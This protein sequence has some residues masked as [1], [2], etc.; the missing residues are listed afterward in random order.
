VSLKGNL[1]N[2]KVKPSLKSEG[3]LFIL[4]LF[5]FG[6]IIL[7]KVNICEWPLGGYLKSFRFF[8]IRPLSIL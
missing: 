6:Y 2:K 5:Y 7:Y 3:F 8:K 1:H 4:N